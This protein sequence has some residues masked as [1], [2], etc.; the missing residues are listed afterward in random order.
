MSEEIVKLINT[1]RIIDPIFAKQ[2]AT[3]LRLLNEGRID[4]ERFHTA[5]SSLVLDSITREVF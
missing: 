2:Y 4:E 3:A 5:L 1:Q